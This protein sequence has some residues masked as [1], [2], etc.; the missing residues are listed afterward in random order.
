[1]KSDVKLSLHCIVGV[2]HEV[3][4]ITNRLPPELADISSEVIPTTTPYDQA[5]RL[6][7]HF[8]SSPTIHSLNFNYPPRSVLEYPE[9]RRELDTWQERLGHERRSY[10]HRKEHLPLAVQR[11]LIGVFYITSTLR[12]CFYGFT[13]T[14]G[15]VLLCGMCP[16]LACNSTVW[17]MSIILCFSRHLP[18]AGVVS[19][20]I[21]NSSANNDCQ[22]QEAFISLI[23]W[24]T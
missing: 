23:K 14:P 5:I 7:D 18:P 20:G 8:I 21:W 12:V 15:L 2:N 9:L 6:T 3:I 10:R 17:N 13:V 22:L 16:R 24:R 19:Q 4:R 1:M 11:K